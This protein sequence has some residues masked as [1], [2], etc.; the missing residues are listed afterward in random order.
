M[1]VIRFSLAIAVIIVL[2]VLTPQYAI[3]GL[4]MT[5]VVALLDL[6][7]WLHDKYLL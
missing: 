2:A 4:F 3:V 6:L 1:S 5:G 7:I